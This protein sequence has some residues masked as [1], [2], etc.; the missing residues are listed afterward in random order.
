MEFDCTSV[1]LGMSGGCFGASLWHRRYLSD[2]LESKVG[3]GY[4]V[5]LVVPL[6]ICCILSLGGGPFVQPFQDSYRLARAYFL[7][8][9]GMIVRNCVRIKLGQRESESPRK[10]VGMNSYVRCVCGVYVCSIPSGFSIQTLYTPLP[11]P[12]R[13]TCHAHLIHLDFI[14]PTILGEQYRSLSSSWCRFLHSPVTSSLLGP[15]I[16]LNTLFSNI[17]SLRS[18]LD[19]SDQVS[20]PY[21]TTGKITV[22]YILTFKFLDSELED[23]RLCTEWQQAFNDFNLLL[24]PSWIKL[25]FVKVTP[26][27]YYQN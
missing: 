17:I 4:E 18:S 7:F 20:H 27:N 11:S 19:V 24:T 25:W 10:T 15:N 23:K 3:E 21:K 5:L 1:V 16:L 14:T 26:F 9:G 6:R 12:I 8:C 22:L 13:A 2:A